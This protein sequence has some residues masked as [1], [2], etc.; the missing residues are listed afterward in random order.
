MSGESSPFIGRVRNKKRVT[1]GLSQLNPQAT[2]FPFLNW[3]Y[4]ETFGYAF[5]IGSDRNNFI[6]Y[7]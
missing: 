5:W 1:W 7:A 3:I 6:C 4:P 2:A